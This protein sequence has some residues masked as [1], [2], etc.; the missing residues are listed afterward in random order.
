[1]PPPSY[2]PAKFLTGISGPPRYKPSCPAVAPLGG[3][4]K[5]RTVGQTVY[6]REVGHGG[7]KAKIKEVLG[8]TQ[9]IATGKPVILMDVVFEDGM[10]MRRVYSTSVFDTAE[11]ASADLAA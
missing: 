1:M 11:A 4:G 9:D 6:V 2:H 5:G 7:R 10:P 3:D 8:P